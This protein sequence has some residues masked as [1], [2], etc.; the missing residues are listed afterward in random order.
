ME[1]DSIE[2]L[3]QRHYGNLAPTPHALEQRLFAAV[4][5]EAQAERKQQQMATNLREKRV[6]RRQVFRL[7][8]P[9]RAGIGLLVVGLEGLQSLESALNSHD[10][11]Q[12]AY[13]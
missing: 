11:T 5:V 8:S 2:A 13:S 7:A 10:G 3:L 9:R 12:P 1:N 4:R 6:S